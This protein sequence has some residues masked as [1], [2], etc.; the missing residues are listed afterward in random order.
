MYMK[1]LLQ[2]PIVKYLVVG[3]GS[4]AIDYDLLLFQYHELH[5]PLG[6]AS[7]ISFCVGLLVNFALN[8]YW[9]FNA[10]RGGKQSTQQAVMYGVL[11]VVNVLFTSI[12]I[13]WVSQYHIGPEISKLFTTALTTLW[14]YVLYKAVIFKGTDTAEDPPT[15]V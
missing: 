5:I 7:A 11:V 10:A 3:V 8:K 2:K 9:A 13:S 15:I 14:N 4:L 12:F 6:I 1:Q